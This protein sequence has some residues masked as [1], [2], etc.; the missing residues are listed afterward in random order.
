MHI[1]SSTA[2]LNDYFIRKVQ[3]F[4]VSCGI[5]NFRQLWFVRRLLFKR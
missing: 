5:L 2:F 1:V 3:T 4:T